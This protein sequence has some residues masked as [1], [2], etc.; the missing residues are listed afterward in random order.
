MN[1]IIAIGENKDWLDKVK[2]ALDQ[3]ANISLIQC[4][5]TLID[6]LACLPEA[7]MNTLLL[8]DANSKVNITE[9]V[10]NLSQRGW[11]YIVVVAADPSV[12]EAYT[13]LHESGGYDYWKQTY[14]IPTIRAKTK[15]CLSEIQEYSLQIDAKNAI[16]DPTE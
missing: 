6:S 1:K 3:D 10:S 8:V 16:T 11:K 7:D 15:K 14:D 5:N 9:V 4:G 12:K 2:T 13:I